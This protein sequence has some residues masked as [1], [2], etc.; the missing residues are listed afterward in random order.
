MTKDEVARRVQNIERLANDDEGA[1]AAEDACGAMSC[2]QL[3]KE[4]R[5]RANSPLRH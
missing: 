4:P 3:L 1:H 2:G 5:T